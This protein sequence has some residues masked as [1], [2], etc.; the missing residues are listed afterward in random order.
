MSIDRSSEAIKNGGILSLPII[1]LSNHFS[2]R[3]V[4]K[5][6]ER[7]EAIVSKKEIKGLITSILLIFASNINID[8]RLEDK[9]ITNR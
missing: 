2:G 7:K 3:I 4:I 9:N 1:H 5:A 6:S 8:I